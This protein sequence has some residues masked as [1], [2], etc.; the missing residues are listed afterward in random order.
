MKILY[1]VIFSKKTAF[2][3]LKDIFPECFLYREKYPNIDP[4][5]CLT[6]ENV[7]HVGKNCMESL[8]KRLGLL[9]KEIVPTCKLVVLYFKR[10]NGKIGG[11]VFFDNL[12]DFRII[13]TMNPYAWEK[14]KGR[15]A[16]YQFVPHT[17]FFMSGQS[18]DLSETSR[19]KSDIDK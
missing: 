18:S 10:N 3:K 9:F 14:I 5:I 4:I 19:E 12:E 6:E 2:F 8:I 13:Q 11:G 16:V 17:E 1:F 7:C 15:G